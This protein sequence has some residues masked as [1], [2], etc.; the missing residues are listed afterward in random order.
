MFGDCNW[1]NWHTEFQRARFH[2]W[3]DTVRAPVV[4]EIGAGRSIP[5]VREFGERLKAL[6]IR[7]NPTDAEVERVDDVSLE[8]GAL[9]AITA[10]AKRLVNMGFVVNADKNSLISA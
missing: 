9:A 6:L 5:S 2:E 10:I 7:V 3:R 4:I 1:V 8:M